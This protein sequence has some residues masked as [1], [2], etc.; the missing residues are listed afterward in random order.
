MFA[1]VFTSIVFLVYDTVIEK[2]QRKVMQT[3]TR[4]SAIVSSLFPSNVRTRLYEESAPTVNPEKDQQ[5]FSQQMRMKNF[6]AKTQTTSVEP[7]NTGPIADLFES[8]TV[9]FADIKG[10]TRWCVV[11]SWNS[12]CSVFNTSIIVGVRRGN[13]R[14]YSH[15]W[16]LCMVPTTSWPKSGE[17][18]RLKPLVTRKWTITHLSWSGSWLTSMLCNRYVAV[19][20]LPEPR[21]DHA[22]AMTKF[23]IDMRRKTKELVNGE[24]KDLLGAGTED[25]EMRIGL[26][27]GP[28]TGGVL[29]GQRARFQLFGDTVNTASR[30]ES[31]GQ[32]GKIHVTEATAHLLMADGKGKWLVKRSELV[33]AKGKGEMQT[34]WVE[35]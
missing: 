12:R 29:R 18:T 27:S 33:A 8:T 31:N 11:L 1:V 23:A 6:M 19:C 28:T 5:P 15:C 34:Y 10:F 25:L 20:G 24:L 30:M 26:H 2:R 17:C 13:P 14:R 7:I 22:L 32:G 21:D 4:S 9:L 3:A 16:R 35:P